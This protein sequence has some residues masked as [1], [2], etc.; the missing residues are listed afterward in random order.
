[1]NVPTS[2]LPIFYSSRRSPYALR[3]RMALAYAQ[4]A[5]EIREIALG[6]KPPQML[7]CSPKGVVPV[8]QLPNGS[9]IDESLEVM[10]WALNQ[11]DPDG[12]Q[13]TQIALTAELILGNDTSFKKNLDCYKY[14]SEASEHPR[15]HY[16]QLAA[17]F[18]RHLERCLVKQEGR[19]LVR[20][21]IS[22][23]DIAIFPFVRQFAETDQ[24]WFDAAPYP[25]LHTWLNVHIRSDRFALAMKKYPLWKAGDSTTVESWA[26]LKP[27]EGALEWVRVK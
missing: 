25:S 26:P 8:L 1:M 20:G 22:L 12:W 13:S 16:H 11:S 24:K 18:L 4:V 7:M 6:E 5:V 3:A 2:V 10:R 17:E 21:T 19:G 27:A 23:A 14:H 15:T 9:V